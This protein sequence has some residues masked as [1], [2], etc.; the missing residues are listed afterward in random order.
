MDKRIGESGL[1]RA[2]GNDIRQ[3]PAQRFPMH[4][5]PKAPCEPVLK[6]DSKHEANQSHIEEWVPSFNSRVGGVGTDM[7]D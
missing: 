1:H 4:P 2:T 5:S 3:Y 7:V 6:R